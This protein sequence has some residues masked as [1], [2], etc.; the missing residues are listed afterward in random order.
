MESEWDKF[1]LRGEIDMSNADSVATSLRNAAAQV[2]SVREFLVD[3]MDLTF[4]DLAGIRALIMVHGEL[5]QQ[6]RDLR[7][8]HASPFLTRV[9]GYVEYTYLLKPSPLHADLN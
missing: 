1:F 6:G 4:I 3:C 5:A 2:P 9:L 7:L 8:V